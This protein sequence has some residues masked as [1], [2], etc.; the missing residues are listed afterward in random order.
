MNRMLS[1]CF[2]FNLK[3]FKIEVT[4]Y[5]VFVFSFTVCSLPHF[6]KVPG[7]DY[8]CISDLADCNNERETHSFL[9]EHQGNSYGLPHFNIS[10]PLFTS[11]CINWTFKRFDG[12]KRP[13]YQFLLQCIW[14]ASTKCVLDSRQH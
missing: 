2:P 8:G 6:S 14:T 13:D 10:V 12:H 3:R 5:L 1:E 7:F 9:E 4:Y 11:P